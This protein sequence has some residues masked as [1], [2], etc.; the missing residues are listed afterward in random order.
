MHTCRLSLVSTCL[1]YGNLAAWLAHLTTWNTDSLKYGTRAVEA[2]TGCRCDQAGQSAAE[3]ARHQR[4]RAGA[5]QPRA[6]RVSA[7]AGVTGTWSAFGSERALRRQ[8]VAVGSPQLRRAW[9]W[10]RS[11]RAPCCARCTCTGCSGQKGF[12]WGWEW[13]CGGGGHC[14]R[15]LR[16]MTPSQTPQYADPRGCGMLASRQ[17]VTGALAACAACKQCM[18]CS[19]VCSALLAA[20]AGAHREAGNP[21]VPGTGG[22]CV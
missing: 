9:G 6:G 16:C 7:A 11:P 14:L 15:A 18:A 22:A 1:C 20:R 17:T 2:A 5:L 8:G 4:R 21:L 10:D 12:F 19:P 3:P 13:G